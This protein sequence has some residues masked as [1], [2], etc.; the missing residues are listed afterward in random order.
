MN[1]GVLTQ[2]EWTNPY[3]NYD[4]VGNALLSLFVAVTLN[5]YSREVPLHAF[6]FV[7]L[8]CLPVQTAKE[9]FNMIMLS[10][11]SALAL[12][13]TSF[14]YGY[15]QIACFL[16]CRTLLCMAS[17]CTSGTDSMSVLFSCNV[18]SNGGAGQ[19]E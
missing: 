12:Q 9:V 13:M 10:E 18:C 16:A 7:Q 14:S 8:C 5:G 15:D 6:L 1:D 3:Q 11:G 4:N 2:R 17:R 19:Q